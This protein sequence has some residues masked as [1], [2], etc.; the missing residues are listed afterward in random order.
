MEELLKYRKRIITN[1]VFLLILSVISVFLV[2][3]AAKFIFGQGAAILLL[4]LFL[5]QVP[6]ILGLGF[7]SF[8][9]INI[10]LEIEEKRRT[11][12]TDEIE[13]LEKEV[14]VKAKE[15]D[16]L[17]FN[18]NRLN[19]D[20][21]KYSDWESFGSA[22][23]IGLSKQ[24]EIVVGMVY[25]Y[26]FDEKK[27]FPVAN[28]AY[29]SDVPPS[30]FREGD[31]LSGQVVKDKK[32]MFINELPEGYVKVMSGLGSHKPRF[33]AIIPFIDDQ[34]VVGVIELAT[35][36]PIERGLSHK[37]NEIAEFIGKKAV[38]ITL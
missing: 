6:L 24:I 13:E 10:F 18:L 19:D 5:I 28:Y 31:G 29:Y 26:D 32:A 20:L 9:V 8:R 3:W 33:L 38:T 35:F 23:L 17:S 16:D 4:S 37:S 14:E 34:Q 21:G 11:I 1:F 30:E 15:A 22:L 25:R 27:Y 36:K 7:N 12:R 2:L